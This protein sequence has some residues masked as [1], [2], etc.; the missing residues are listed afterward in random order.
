M[1]ND[2]S[3]EL[4]GADEEELFS[5]VRFFRPEVPAVST[6]S[7]RNTGFKNSR[8]SLKKHVEVGP[9]NVLQ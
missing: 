4:R 3:G 6:K 2:Y 5:F 8:S 9:V 1:V 7:L